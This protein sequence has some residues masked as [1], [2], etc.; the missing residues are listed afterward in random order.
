MS[1]NRITQ[2]ID[3]FIPKGILDEKSEGMAVPYVA[4]C[5]FT[6]LVSLLCLVLLPFTPLD[7][8]ELFTAEAVGVITILGYG[9]SLYCL[10]YG[11]QLT[12]AINVYSATVFANIIATVFLTGGFS[13][14]PQMI[15]LVFI[16]VWSFLMLEPIYGLLASIA[17]ALAVV[18]LYVLETQGFEFPQY[19]PVD[20]LP[21]MRLQAWIALLAIVVGS[22]YSFSHNYNTLNARL[23]LERS[24]YAY[25]ALHDPLTGLCN[26]TLFYKRAKAA[27]EHTLDGELKVAIIY[28]DIDHFKPVNDNFG[29]DAGDEV[30]IILAQR[31]KAVVRS[32][33]TVA[34]LGGDEFG[35]IL[36]GITDKSVAATLCE[37][38]VEAA[39][40]P[41]AIGDNEF[42]LG[43]SLGVAVGPDNG[44]QLNS[45]IGLADKAMYQAKSSS[46]PI[47][48]V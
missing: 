43:V 35:I 10:R 34:R 28:L 23:E 18:L 2:F 40:L 21:Y 25:D 33:D 19:I 37:K 24:H 6:A 31:I 46:E 45:L 17:V 16:P 44:T 14:S 38:V 8:S 42:Q 30:L 48:F 29:H 12:T 1:A 32:S 41:L 13:A 39:S 15:L 4:V 11:G 26:R 36:H 3:F 7:A 47:C 27:I 5:I 9:L 20:A 22:L